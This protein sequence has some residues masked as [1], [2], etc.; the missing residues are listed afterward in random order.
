VKK[1][2]GKTQAISKKYL[3]LYN[4]LQRSGRKE[5]TISF[6]IVERVLKSTLPISSRISRGWW[7]NRVKGGL[8]SRAWLDAGYRVV[9][10]DFNKA[11]VTFQQAASKVKPYRVGDSIL[12]NADL[13]RALRLHMKMNQTQFAKELGV[14]QQTISEWETSI[15][16]PTRAMS[17]FLTILADRVKF[18]SR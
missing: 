12:W 5:I 4:Y 18:L 14:R 16:K 3:P 15:Y 7:S 1:V 13:I 11:E 9:A 17:K 6:E 10:V 2:K 8:Q